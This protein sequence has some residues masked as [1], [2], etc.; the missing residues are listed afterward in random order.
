M[1]VI[2]RGYREKFWG[3]VWSYCV[4][5]GGVEIKTYSTQPTTK[6]RGGGGGRKRTCGP[7]CKVCL[8]PRARSLPRDLLA[9]HRLRCRSAFDSMSLPQA[10]ET[11]TTY[12]Q[13]DWSQYI[14]CIRYRIAWLPG[15]SGFSA[16]LHPVIVVVLKSRLIVVRLACC[17]FSGSGEALGASG[18][19]CVLSI[20]GSASVLPI[21]CVRYFRWEREREI[22]RE[23]ERDGSDFTIVALIGDEFTLS[24][25]KNS[26]NWR[27]AY[28]FPC[29][30]FA[31]FVSPFTLPVSPFTERSLLWR[32]NSQ[33]VHTFHCQKSFRPL[34]SPSFKAGPP[35]DL[36]FWS[37][38]TFLHH[39]IEK[40]ERH[41]LWKFYK[42]I[43]RKSWSNVP[44]KLVACIGF[45]YKVVH[46]IGRLRKFNR[47]RGI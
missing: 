19:L 2:G 10:R 25:A 39:G 1:R 44:P 8:T 22:Q 31:L 26:H 46:K 41:L 5:Q 15:G 36:S 45:L 40:V 16:V 28:T 24:L 11:S 6:E 33:W 29:Q 47:S 23:R 27:W 38:L 13:T 35:L 21:L 30:K 14:S 32:W 42:K 9:G 7:Q 18:G 37:F 34:C 3:L 43:Q 20:I 12:R 17:Q 4:E